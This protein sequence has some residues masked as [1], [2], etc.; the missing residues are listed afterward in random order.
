MFFVENKRVLN[1]DGVHELASVLSSSSPMRWL[2]VRRTVTKKPLHVLTKKFGSPSNQAFNG[3][4]RMALPLL[5]IRP[6]ARGEIVAHN[7]ESEEVDFKVGPQE[8]RCEQRRDPNT[9]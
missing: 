8:F 7:P 5:D 4:N 9:R 6:K 3:H 1:V 2:F